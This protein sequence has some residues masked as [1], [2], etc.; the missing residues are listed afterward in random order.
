MA[1]VRYDLPRSCT[2]TT[3]PR[4]IPSGLSSTA[5]ILFIRV[6]KFLPR[7]TE[8]NREFCCEKF[9]GRCRRID[10]VDGAKLRFLGIIGRLKSPS[11]EKRN[12][13]TSLI[14]SAYC[15]LTLTRWK[16]CRRLYS[17]TVLKKQVALVRLTELLS[18]NASSIISWI[19]HQIRS[20]P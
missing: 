7:T 20:I 9:L 14:N 19:S 3:K 6:G 12:N 16:S 15:F 2:F 8:N 11:P 4:F 17:I 18:L 1:R 13:P 5:M 10:E